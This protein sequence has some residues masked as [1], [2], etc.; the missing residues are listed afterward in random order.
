[1][2][3]KVWT[4]KVY[5]SRHSRRLVGYLHVEGQTRNDAMALLAR[6]AVI[7]KGA[8]GAHARQ[9]LEGAVR[10]TLVPDY[11]HSNY[12]AADG[13]WRGWGAAAWLEDPPTAYARWEEN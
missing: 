7:A 12:A 9:V 8:A 11:L 13:T 10:A 5:A 2:S 6:M 3:V 1:M 4:S